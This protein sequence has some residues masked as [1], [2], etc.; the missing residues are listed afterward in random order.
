[1]PIPGCCGY[2]EQSEISL[3]RLDLGVKL[4]SIHGQLDALVLDL[5]EMGAQLGVLGR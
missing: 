4:A 2:S 1:M 3:Q 5:R